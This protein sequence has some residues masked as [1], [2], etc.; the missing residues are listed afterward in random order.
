M[1]VLTTYLTQTQTKGWMST[2]DFKQA[3][4]KANMHERAQAKAKQAQ[5]GSANKHTPSGQK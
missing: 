4:R 2:N 3:Q 5:P 1:F